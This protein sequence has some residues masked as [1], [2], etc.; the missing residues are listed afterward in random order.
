MVRELARA[1]GVAAALGLAG[2]CAGTTAS[3]GG[4]GGGEAPQLVRVAY[5]HHSTGGN[6][7]AGGVPR[8]IKGH[9]A[10]Q[11][12]WYQ[13]T[14]ITYPSTRGGYPWANYPWDYWNLW[15]NHTGERQDRGELNLDQLAADHDVIVFKHC[16]PV[17][18]I[19]PDSASS[20]PSVESQARTVANY[21]LQ[22]EALRMRMRE[23]PSKKFIVWTGAALTQR[24]TT[25]AE[26]ERAREF[27]DWVKATW[28]EPG[29]NV[30]VWDFHALETDGGLYLKSS[31]AASPGDSHPNHFF[32][33]KAAPLLGRR[34]VDVIEGRGDTGSLTGG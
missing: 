18:G 12:T 33:G 19:A 10:R 17:S 13:I 6:V 30:F 32:S 1:F 28:D 27:F 23:Y 31:H 21:K 26:A 11:G 14:P 15:V 2:G 4:A 20:P 29:D 22:Y 24:S 9:N 7:W 34:I 8:F 5:L 16:F 3:S 25:E